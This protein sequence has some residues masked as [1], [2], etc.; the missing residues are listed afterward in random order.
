MRTA[1]QTSG[2]RAL[3]PINQHR[4]TTGAPIP[5]PVGGWDAQSPL[6]AMPAKNAV[7]L[8]NFI[9]RAGFVELRR[10]YVP[11]ATGLML[12]VESLLIWRGGTTDEI[13]AASGGSIYDVS[14][15]D[16]A[17]VEVQSGTGNARWQHINFAND[18]GAFMVAAN[19]A[20]DP[21]RYDGSSFASLSIT[22]SAGVITLDPRTLVD[23]MSH[24][25]R[26]FWVQRDSLRVWYLEPF[27][28]QGTANLLDL[29]PIFN[30][31]GSLLCQGT[32]TL[33]GG[34]GADDLAVF[35]TTEG[36]VAIYQG[37]D[38]SDAD[39]WALVGVYDLGLPLS[40]RSL[41][42]YGSDLVLL[43][44]D[45]VIP[46][47]Q[48]LTLDRSKDDLVALTQK[49]HEAFETAS[50]RYRNNFGWEMILY[51]KGTL[52][53]CNVPVAALSQSEQYV[54]NVST[55]AWCRFK[56]INA[57]CWG[58]ANDRPYFGTTDG[59]AVWDEGYS[60][61]TA[62]ITGD[63]LTAYNYFGSRGSLKKFES[64]QPVLRIAS[65]L[66]P[67][68]E[69]VTDF[70][71]KVPTAVPTT[72]RT[73]GAPWDEGLWDVA[74][75]SDATETRDSW[76]GVTGIGYCGAVRMRVAPLPVIPVL[77]SDGD[78]AI[79]SYD[80]LGL[81]GTQQIRNTNAAVEVIAF[82]LKYQNQ[83]GGQF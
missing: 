73:S 15:Q 72:I 65:N 29:G 24:K 22:G 57:F 80:G 31:G 13:F 1:L 66:A 59:V 25:G 35:V 27:A 48:A 21:I 20:V 79:I 11:W 75:W 14:D 36:Q 61:D 45:G 70:K 56:G 5:A 71:D 9:P 3:Q 40:R 83:T 18:A 43:T 50:E 77:L 26:L 38:P 64:L 32:W 46:L 67:A 7:I 19:G 10:G 16:A 34:S 37:L 54:Q 49:I 6:A 58:I 81:V 28:I 78:G 2:R 41:I 33:D 62:G 55:G 51:Q 8:D 17:P 69:V 82:N 42:K 60:D 74:L 4:V 23:V 76:T 39:N 68:M 44:T 30:K 63:I 53:I 52:A 47:S 12:P